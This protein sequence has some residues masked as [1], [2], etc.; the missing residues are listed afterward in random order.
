MLKFSL[1]LKVT[2]LSP[3]SKLSKVCIRLKWEAKL[4]SLPTSFGL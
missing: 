3:F 2:E 4:P 1:I